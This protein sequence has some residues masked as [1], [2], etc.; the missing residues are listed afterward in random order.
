M[1]SCKGKEPTVEAVKEIVLGDNTLTAQ[2]KEEGWQLLFD[3]K[4]LDGWHVFNTDGDDGKWE[5]KDGTLWFNTESE[6]KSGDITSD[7]T[8]TNFEFSLEWNISACGN[9]GIFWGV[10]EDGVYDR[11]F[12]SAPEMQVLDNTCHPDAKI[13]T[14][15]AGDLYDLIPTSSMTVKPAGEWNKV[16]IKND[17]GKVT[18]W[19][20]DVEVVKFEMFTD[21]WKAMLADSKFVEWPEFG[22]YRTGK[23][24]LQDHGNDVWFKNIKV[25][26]L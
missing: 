21:E 10:Q 25:K 24:A 6:G 22:T 4:T 11:T 12:K 14:H 16:K 20:N 9:S 2:E 23:L 17:N 18:F 5:V 8:Y 13:H 26:E 19:Q 7:K 3:G 15:K 1:L